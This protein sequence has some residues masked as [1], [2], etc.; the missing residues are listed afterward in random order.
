MDRL[1]NYTTGLS[2]L[3]MLLEAMSWQG[4]DNLFIPLGGFLLLR[5]FMTLDALALGTR[6][7]VTIVLLTFVLITRRSQALGENAMLAGV[8][9]GYVAWSVGGW[10]W[11]MP[12]LILFILYNIVFPRSAGT[13]TMIIGAMRCS[14]IAFDT[15]AT[16]LGVF[17]RGEPP[18]AGSS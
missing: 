9:V 14:R 3:L 4:L 18:L 11:L 6:L 7:A 13:P 16:M 12:P 2:V 15:R 17:L 8:L 5:V 10:T 1:L